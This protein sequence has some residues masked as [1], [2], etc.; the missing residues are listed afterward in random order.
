M[1]QNSKEI[2][3][4]KFIEQIIKFK[5]MICDNEFDDIEDL[6]RHLISVVNLNASLQDH[7]CDPCKLI[8]L[9]ESFPDNIKIDSVIRVKD[10]HK[11]AENIYVIAKIVGF[12]YDQTW[13]NLRLFLDRCAFQYESFRQ[14]NCEE[15]YVNDQQCAIYEILTKKE[16]E[17]G[18]YKQ[19]KYYIFND[20]FEKLTE[21][22]VVD[23]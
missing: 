13:H 23:Y 11:N 14:N 3:F 21:D 7:P 9:K 17:D 1:S 4:S 22:M 16:K 20:Q 19:N 6:K 5:C 8:E 12:E 18:N 2:D 10:C 15:P